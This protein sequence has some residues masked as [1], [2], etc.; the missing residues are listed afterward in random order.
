MSL[1]IKLGWNNHILL[2]NAS[3]TNGLLNSLSDA[4]CLTEEYD[5]K[6]G[7][8]KYKYD[9]NCDIE[10]KIVPSNSLSLPSNDDPDGLAMRNNQLKEE[11]DRLVQKIAELEG[12][13]I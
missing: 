7:K 10:I 6:E 11:R 9:K 4:V 3:E 8:Y 2:P 1:I 5:S 13:T 12:K